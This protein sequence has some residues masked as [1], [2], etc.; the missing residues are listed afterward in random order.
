MAIDP[1]DPSEVV[2]F[3][4]KANKAK[5]LA[6]WLGFLQ[7]VCASGKLEQMEIEPLR[8]ESMA[9]LG[10][11]RDLDALELLRDLDS[12]FDD[13]H[14]EIYDVLQNIIAQRTPKA[15]D[16]SEDYDVNA[17]YG[18]CAGISCDNKLLFSE[19]EQL[20]G[21]ID[22]APSLVA[23]KRIASL[24]RHAS[25]ALADGVISAEEEADMGLWIRRL[26]GDSFADTGLATLGNT[27]E[28]EGALADHRALD[29]DGTAFVLTGVFSIA[30]RRQLENMLQERGAKI[31]KAV[32]K[33]TSYLAVA[34][35]ASMAWVKSHEGNKL[36]RAR[37]LREVHGKPDFV[38]EGV[39]RKALDTDA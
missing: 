13:Y 2:Y 9:F 5:I 1:E 18:F 32:S 11:F 22:D 20:I 6:Y 34:N 8:A 27:P 21:R 23:D 38:P 17:F 26:V 31:L 30:P 33:T 24:R 28:I 16:R 37:E 10:V 7:G 3:R 25:K 15:R 4:A 36:I 12:A 35:T 19:V 29:F 14:S 39:L